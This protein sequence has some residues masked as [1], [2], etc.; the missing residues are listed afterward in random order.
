MLRRG[1]YPTRPDVRE[2]MCPASFIIVKVPGGAPVSRRRQQSASF[3]AHNTL[4][5]KNI[6]IDE[7][8]NSSLAYC[9]IKK[10]RTRLR[11]RENFFLLY[12]CIFRR[13]FY[14]K[15]GRTRLTLC[16]NRSAVED[17][18]TVNS[19][20]GRAGNGI[21]PRGKSE[22][23]FFAREGC[24]NF[25]RGCGNLVTKTRADKRESD[26]KEEPTR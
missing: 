18:R 2:K 21:S 11:P 3:S 24:E 15:L 5:I 14:F 9:V 13:T 6:H 23:G 10:R 16:T 17:R 4:Y 20:H 12:A 1:C 22:A 7:S 26:G 25:G 8:A 19:S